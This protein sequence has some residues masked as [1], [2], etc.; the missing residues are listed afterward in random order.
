MGR[1]AV[2]GAHPAAPPAPAAARSAPAQQSAAAPPVSSKGIPH[3]A[4]PGFGKLGRRVV[5]RA[6]H[7]LVEVADNDICHYNV[8]SPPLLPIY[9]CTF[10]FGLFFLSFHFRVLLDQ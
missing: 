4:R 6:N 9:S 5:V 7:F 2:A 8:S 10:V 1:L 3:P